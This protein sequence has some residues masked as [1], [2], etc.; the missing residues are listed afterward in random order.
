MEGSAAMAEAAVRAGCRFYAGYPITPSTEILEYMSTRMP[1]VG[2]VCMNAE[3]EIEAIGMVWGAAGCGVR[4]MTAST[5]QGISLMQE[6]FAELANAQIPVVTVNMCRGQGDYFQSTRG[7][8]HGDYRFIVLAPSSAQEA[9]DLAQLAFD[10][11][12]KW[13]NPVMIMGD[14]LLS[15]TSEIVEFHETVAQRSA[16]KSW[17][18]T[19]ARGRRGITLSPLGPSEKLSTDIATT[20]AHAIDKHAA[21]K[22]EE[23]RVDTGYLDDAELVVVAFGFP[24]R[25]V[26]YAVMLARERGLRVGYVRPITLWPFPTQAVAAAAERAQAVAVFELNAGQMIEDVQLAVLGR[27]PVHAIG[28]ISHDHSGFGV[29]PLLNVEYILK[30]IEEVYPKKGSR[31]QGN[32]G[33]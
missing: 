20:L 9:A 28:G 22:A 14:F 25:F 1:Q 5:G 24:G 29:G 19:G 16:D 13:R 32:L 6:S 18:I 8:G 17:A 2:G 33:L 7:G 11:A 4:A 30:R 21:I 12:D 27:A 15:H 10:L 23:V 31:V 3:S 26:K